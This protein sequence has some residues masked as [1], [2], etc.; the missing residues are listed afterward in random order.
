M[1]YEGHHLNQKHINMSRA[2]VGSC[3]EDKPHA[4]LKQPQSTLFATQ[5]NKMAKVG[6]WVDGGGGV[7]WGFNA[8]A[9]TVLPVLKKCK[10]P[11][12]QELQ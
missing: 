3:A 11:L 5:P 9:C 7:Y 2:R 8:G 12:L 1:E 10:T 4:R 6:G